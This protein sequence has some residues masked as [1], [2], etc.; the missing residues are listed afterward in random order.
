MTGICIT[1][2]H[3]DTPP[4]FEQFLSKFMARYYS[5]AQVRFGDRESIE[6]DG[7]PTPAETQTAWMLLDVAGTEYYELQL[8]A[9]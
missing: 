9:A 8:Q 5:S 2:R 4:G 6:L 1:I 3:E 7:L